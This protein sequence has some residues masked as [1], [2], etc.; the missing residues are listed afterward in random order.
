M[1]IQSH[2]GRITLHESLGAKWSGLI[3]ITIEGK[4][5]WQFEQGDVVVQAFGSVAAMINN[6]LHSEILG[7]SD[8]LLCEACEHRP[9]RG[10]RK[11]EQE[12]TQQTEESQEAFFWN[13]NYSNTIRFL[14]WCSTKISIIFFSFIVIPNEY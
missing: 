6:F 8:W 4:W 13:N 3:K 14:Y 1:H 10:V 5:L 2:T 7:P 11:A 9:Q 12:T